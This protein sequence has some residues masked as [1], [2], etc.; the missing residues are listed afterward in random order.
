MAKN[1][2]KKTGFFTDASATA[3]EG[4][5]VRQ[6]SEFKGRVTIRQGRILSGT[7][8]S[9]LSVRNLT[10]VIPVTLLSASS[11][12]QQIGVTLPTSHLGKTFPTGLM[13]QIIVDR[14]GGTCTL[15]SSNTH[16]PANVVFTV[17]G[18]GALCRFDGQMWSVL[19]ASFT[20]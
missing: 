8:V 14:V 10:P 15:S 18:Q 1:I 9:D 3:G 13:H 7:T 2:V 16:L 5:E 17:P 20:P 6:N 11:G 19:S 4:F 12:A